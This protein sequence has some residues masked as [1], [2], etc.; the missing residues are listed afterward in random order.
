MHTAVLNS[1]AP[2]LAR[3]DS[4]EQTI[5]DHL[6]KEVAVGL[7]TL[8]RMLPDYSWNQ[9]FHAVDRLARAERIVLRRHGYDDTLF[10]TTYAA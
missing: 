4:L 5:L 9:I 8:I 3:H 6:K 10:S 7:D 1:P 2:V